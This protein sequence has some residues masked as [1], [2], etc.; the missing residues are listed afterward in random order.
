VLD[1]ARELFVAQGYVATT[2]DE[3]AARA[4]VSKPT[5]FAAVGSKSAII[6][7][8]REEAMTGDNE[9]VAVAE[10]PWFRTALNEPDPYESVRLHARMSAGMHRRAGDLNEVLRSG[11]GADLE[12]RELWETAERQRRADAATF[13]DNLMSKTDL[14]PGLHRDAAVDVVW[15]LTSADAFHRLVRMRRWSYQRYDEWLIQTF[16]DQLLPQVGRHTQA[17]QASPVT[18]TDSNPRS[19]GRAVD[20]T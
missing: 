5:V 20:S 13:V 12:L 9:P 2:V 7:R 10:R 1:A 3:I 19:A 6:R 11:A 8:L 16:L 15:V 18:P 17:G 4:G 14:R